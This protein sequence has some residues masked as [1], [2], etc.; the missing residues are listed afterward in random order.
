MQPE[1]KEGSKKIHNDNK[2]KY[3]SLFGNN[4]TP[5]IANNKKHY[6]HKHNKSFEVTEILTRENK[7]VNNNNNNISTYSIGNSNF[8]SFLAKTKYDYKS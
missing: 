5:V 7:Y 8:A 3:N 6:E 1:Y 4:Y 2:N